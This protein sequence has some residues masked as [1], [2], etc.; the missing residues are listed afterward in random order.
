LLARAQPR[1]EG[2]DVEIGEAPGD[3]IRRV[4]DLALAAEED[5]D[6]ARA[7]VEALIDRVGDG[8]ERVGVLRRGPIKGLDGIRPPTHLHDRRV[9]EVRGEARRVDR[10]RRDD[11]LQ[12]RPP[13][14]D[15]LQVAEEEVDVERPLVRLVDDDRVVAAQQP[16]VL[17]LGEQEAV[18]HDAHGRPARGPVVE[19]H[20]V[21]DDVAERHAQLERDP[22]GHRPC[23]DP[24]R[25]RV[26]DRLAPQLEAQLRELRRLARPR[27][28][29][30]HDDLMRPD[31]RQQVLAPGADRQLR[32][33]RNGGLRHA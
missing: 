5:E 19:A 12:V 23:R 4:A 30:H 3:E 10:G 29:R 6:V 22:L 25:L 20:G 21:P 28:A 11:E 8:V 17:D 14:Q 24:P 32:R 26:R 16:V 9:V 31:R 7:G 15:R 18:G 13:R 27:L 2:D 33:I 1:V